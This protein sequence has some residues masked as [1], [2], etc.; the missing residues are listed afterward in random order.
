[1][2][3]ELTLGEEEFLELPTKRQNLLLFKNQCET[4]KLIRGYKFYYKLTTIIGSALII[5]EGI[6]FNLHLT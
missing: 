5:G 3:N 1:M 6:L 2:V 4:I